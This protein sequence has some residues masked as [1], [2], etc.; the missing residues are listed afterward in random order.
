MAAAQASGRTA[1]PRVDPLSR[2][3]LF[4]QV[5]ALVGAVLLGFLAMAIRQVP[6]DRA[7]LLVR[8]SILTAATVAATVLVPWQRIP[9]IVHRVLPLVYLIVVYFTRDATGGVSS[10]YAQLALLPLLW[11]AVYGSLLE[12]GGTL[13][14]TAVV[15]GFPLARAGAAEAEW[16]RMLAMLGAGGTLGYIV[17][18]FFGQVRHQTG[19]LRV[20]AGTDPLTGTANRRAWDDELSAAIEQAEFDGR[21]MSVALL[22]LDD[23]K[24]YNDRH[25]HQAG[26]RLL[27]EVSAAWQAILRM[28]D[29]LARIGGDEFAVL[30]PGCALETA[31]QIAE[32]LRSAVPAANCSVGVASWDRVET[33]EELLARADGALYEAKEGGR[34]QVVVAGE[35]P[36]TVPAD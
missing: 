35:G 19:K 5:G 31:A 28:S 11:V 2:D 34:G 6:D 14:A 21:P 20:L 10:S 4:R 1:P 33:V 18:R 24:G 23:F 30:L 26:D 36:H 9:P 13:L 29:V 16:M 27:K 3:V 17:C 12:L 15:L 8:A 22:D 32:R 25:G 7:G